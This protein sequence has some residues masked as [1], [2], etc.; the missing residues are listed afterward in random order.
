MINTDSASLEFVVITEDT[1]DCG[2]RQMRDILK[3]IFLENNIYS[4]LD[5]SGEFFEWFGKRNEVVQKQVGL[6]EFENI[7]QGIICSLHQSERILRVIWHLLQ[8]Q[9]EMQKCKRG[10]GID[11]DNYAS[12][13]LILEEAEERIKRFSKKQKQTRFQNKKGNGDGDGNDR[14]IRIWTTQR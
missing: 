11:F 3:Q 14:Q 13:I 7:D 9:Q 5:L 2:E 6:Y 8:N 10:H 4:R 1:C 12:R